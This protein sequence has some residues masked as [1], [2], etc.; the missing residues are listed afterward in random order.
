MLRRRDAAT[1]SGV[2]ALLSAALASAAL[3]GSPP[4]QAALSRLVLPVMR[5]ELSA[6]ADGRRALALF[7]GAPAPEFGDAGRALAVLSSGRRVVFSAAA[8][9]E[10]LAAAGRPESALESDPRLR[11]ELARLLAPAFVHESEHL[12]LQRQ[13]E[14]RGV[15]LAASQDE[16]V[17]AVRAE[18]AFVVEQLDRDPSWEARLVRLS[19]AS[20]LART[21]L[22]RGRRLRDDGDEGLTR[23]TRALYSDLLT[24]PAA[25]AR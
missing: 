10:F 21:A 9:R 4:P 22:T 5:A 16:E 11:V 25:A 19:A 24:S 17:A 6:S 13:A 7:A 3:A 12:R 18:A 15:T 2:N 1:L 20:A 14:A 8:V 23:S